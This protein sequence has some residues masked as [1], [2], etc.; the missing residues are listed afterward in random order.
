MQRVTPVSNINHNV[1]VP[2]T[3]SPRFLMICGMSKHTALRHSPP[4]L[5]ES[6]VTH[7]SSSH[8]LSTE[9][10]VAILFSTRGTPYQERLRTQLSAVVPCDPLRPWQK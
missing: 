3:Q 9:R 8:S 10:S 4:C 5:C 6:M 7:I 2:V 1:V